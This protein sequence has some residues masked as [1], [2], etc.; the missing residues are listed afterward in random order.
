MSYFSHT[1]SKNPYVSLQPG[2][3]IVKCSCESAYGWGTSFYGT[4]SVS[5]KKI[6]K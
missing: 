1:L 2:T 3:Y 6:K 4:K 5:I